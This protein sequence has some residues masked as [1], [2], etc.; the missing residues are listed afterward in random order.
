MSSLPLHPT[1]SVGRVGLRWLVAASASVVLTVA[2]LWAVVQL[3]HM[4]PTAPAPR[5][6]SRDRAIAIAAPP[7]PPTETA[8]A[9]AAPDA[10]RPAEA[11]P[12]N[13]PVAP[14]PIAPAAVA[15]AAPG[16]GLSGVALGGGA[17]GLPSV[18]DL[19]VSA[20]PSAPTEAVPTTSAKALSRPAPTYPPV[21]ARKGIEGEVTVRLRIDET[22]RVTDAVVVSSEPK[23][24]FDAA[25]LRTARRY[26]FT[27]AKKGDTPVAST[28]QQTI[29]FELQ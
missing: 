27:P 13:E 9:L 20:L 17:G 18:G 10:A 23:G 16:P 1:T 5:A 22:G 14:P 12:P 3:N 24:V 26:R 11:A 2:S 4:P 19:P 29:R 7:P 6:T 25:A 21:A 8:P 15:A 28:T